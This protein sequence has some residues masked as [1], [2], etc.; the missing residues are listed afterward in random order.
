MASVLRLQASLET[1]ARSPEA[2]RSQHG[3]CESA[4]RCGRS[5]LHPSLPPRVPYNKSL[6]RSLVFG[7]ASANENPRAPAMPTTSAAEFRR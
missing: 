4:I 1:D 7:M 2:E 5:S 6:Q 3:I